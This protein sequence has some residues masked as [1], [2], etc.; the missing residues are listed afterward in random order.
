VNLKAILFDVDDTL[1]DRA[2][3]QREVARLIVRELDDV[4]AGLD[5]QRVV[6]AFVESDRLTASE[7]EAGEIIDEF[8]LWRSRVFLGLLGLDDAHAGA[9]AETYVRLYPRVDTPVA[10]ARSVVE[11]LAA[12]YQLGVVSNGLPDVQYRKLET[13]GLGDAFA[14][15]VLSGA[16]EIWKPDPRIFARAIGLLGREPGECLYV[17]NSYEADVVGAKGAGM[18]AC[19]LN[20]QGAPVPPGGVV[21]DFEI[22][23]L[24]ELCEI[25]GVGCAR[26][27]LHSPALC[28]GDEREG[29][30]ARG[31]KKEKI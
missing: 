18:R 30:A 3:A 16:C 23:A 25:A 11:R 5:E 14:C 15:V 4:F 26:R 24:E 19:W 21:P 31:R 12:R 27:V 28:G 2:R 6:E 20:P 13:L 29:S 9:A 22:G 7:Y 10:G 8:R 17:G 1:F